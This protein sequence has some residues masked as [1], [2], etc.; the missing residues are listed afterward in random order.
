MF[1]NS[2]KIN[3]LKDAIEHA[4]QL[5]K[6]SK[7]DLAKKFRLE[8]NYNSNHIEGSKLTYGE[9][10]LLLIFDQTEGNHTYREY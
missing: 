2:L 6:K 7:T 4:P 10:E 9:T 5:T 8:F 1:R 3:A